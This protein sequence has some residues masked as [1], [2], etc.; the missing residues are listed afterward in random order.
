[1]TEMRDMI[2]RDLWNANQSTHAQAIVN[3][4]FCFGFKLR[5]GDRP[6]STKDSSTVSS[7]SVERTDGT[8][9]L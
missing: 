9:T 5:P 4:N 8:Q 7:E 3:Q 2:A 1:M 6:S